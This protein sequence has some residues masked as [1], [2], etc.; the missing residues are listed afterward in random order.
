MCINMLKMIKII[1]YLVICYRYVLTISMCKFWLMMQIYVYFIWYYKPLAY[2]SMRKY[3]G[4]IIGLTAT[5]AK[6][7]NTCS[8]LLP[9]RALFR[10]RHGIVSVWEGEGVS[11]QCDFIIRFDL[12]LSV[13]ANSNSV[14]S[15]WMTV[16]IF[17]LSLVYGGGGGGGGE[18]QRRHLPYI[19]G[20]KS[21]PRIR[22]TPTSS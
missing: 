10:M 6:L 19:L 8:D 21:H 1:S 22:R 3:N 17:F 15:K 5:A 14:E 18:R 4:N 12:Y 13:L 2:I 20:Y 16:G 9:V 11:R 7:G